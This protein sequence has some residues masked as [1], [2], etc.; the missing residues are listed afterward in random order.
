MILTVANLTIRILP[1]KQY[2]SLDYSP[3]HEKFL[4]DARDFQ[5][6]KKSTEKSLLLQI[7]DTP[8]F[9]HSQLTRL[10]C[11]NEIW[12]LWLDERENFIFTQPKQT[13]QRWIKIDPDFQHGEIIGN[14]SKFDQNGVYPLQYIDIVIFSNWLAN[15]GDMILHASGFAYRG[16]GYCFLGDSGAGKSTLVRDLTKKAGFTV[17]GED[18][19]VLRRRE[20]QF[21]IFGT[22]WHETPDMCS[23]LGVPL[24][25]VFFLDRD[26]FQ[27]VSPVRGFDAIVQ[28]MQTA[29]YPIYRP[30]VLEGILANLSSLA[31]SVG[32]YNLAYERGT[33]VLN[34]IL[35][36]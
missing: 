6:D 26:A 18:Q 20:D 28:I 33:D 31:G 11:E 16:E 12:Q 13:S 30:E 8:D 34:E 29:F 5:Q 22:P 17:L 36:A 24:K 10:L 14:F 23:P 35:N 2:L 21:M 19:V 4:V 7:R 32:F 27:I 9:L 15:F 1:D 3:C 25:K